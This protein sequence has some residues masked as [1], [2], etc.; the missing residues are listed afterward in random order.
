M[1]PTNDPGRW[2]ELCAAFDTLVQLDASARTERLDVLGASDPASRRALEELLEADA[3]AASWLHPIDAVFGTAVPPGETRTNAVGD[4]LRLVGRNIGHFRVIEPLATGGMGAVYR[5]LDTHLGRPV[6][7]KF[8]LPGQ[9]LDH[10]VREWFLR[11]ARAVGAPR[12]DAA[13]LSHARVPSADR[14]T[15]LHG[16]T[17]QNAPVAD[18]YRAPVHADGGLGAWEPIPALP[19]ATAHH[20]LVSFGPYL[21]VV[22]GDT[23]AVAPG[24][25]GTSGT[26]T[27][28]SYMARIDMRDGTVP[29]WTAISTPGKARGKHGMMSAGGSVVVTSGMYSGQVGSSEN[30][31][32][33]INA[34]GTL[35]TWGGAT[36]SSIIQVVLGYGIFNQAAISFVD[37]V[38]NGHVVVLGGGIR[39]SAGEASAGVVY[40]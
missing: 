35:S 5:G 8:P 37:A 10:Q 26:E 9:R 33:T 14:A 28:A 13:R 20:G 22:G 21:Y 4:P 3:N 36:G 2:A 16:A 7:L 25:S 11:E 12:W 18:A 19:T 15:L 27:A 23:A 40:Y 30:S 39:G 32:A 29:G 31:Y 34:D 38:G 24:N 6:A 1:I 17:G